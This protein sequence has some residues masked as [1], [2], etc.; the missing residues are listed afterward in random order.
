MTKT[1]TGTAEGQQLA[2]PE[3]LLVLLSAWAVPGA[4]HWLL[5]YRRRAIAIA[6]LLLAT[7]LFALVITDGEAGAL[8]AGK[9]AKLGRG[10]FVAWFFELPAGL[11]AVLPAVIDLAFG[12]HEEIAVETVKYLDLGL[13]YCVAVGLLNLLLVVDAYERA[14]KRRGAL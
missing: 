14:L 13:V 7:F 6:V 4:G 2:K 1:K 5:G 8:D 11:V 3:P 12:A 9:N 10:H